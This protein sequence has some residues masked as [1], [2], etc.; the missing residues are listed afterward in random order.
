L[1]SIEAL[2]AAPWNE[3]WSVAG[4]GYRAEAWRVPVENGALAIPALWLE[5]EHAA[6]EPVLVFLSADG[7]AAEA[8]ESGSLAGLARAGRRV[9]A[10][11]VRGT[12]ETHQRRQQGMTAAVGRDYWDLYTAHLLGRTCVGMQAE[13]VLVA[14]REALRRSGRSQVDLVAVG[15]VG[16]PA[17]HAAFSQP[18]SFRRVMLDQV[19]TS[20]DEVVRADRTYGQLMTVVFGALTTYDLPD[21]VAALGPAVTVRNPAGVTGVVRDPAPPSADD[22]LPSRPGLV[23]VIFGSPGFINPQSTDQLRQ[24]TA[25][26]G[27]DLGHDWSA[28]WAGSL[29]PGVS[30]QI[31]LAVETNEEVAVRLGDR[32]VLAAAQTEAPVTAVVT[33]AAGQAVPFGVDFIKPRREGE[34]RDHVSILRLLWRQSGGPWQAL[35]AEWIRHSRAEENAAELSLR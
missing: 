23:G 32:V 10:V 16:V 5:P 14:V 27:T 15:G 21:L 20:W 28:R 24:G 9:L 13:D 25:S 30:G 3:A 1:R 17:L 26:W 22:L 11:D 35:P 19:L 12:G 8:A 4:P 7:F 31:T 33:V 6:D 2:P 29:V 34:L 18:E